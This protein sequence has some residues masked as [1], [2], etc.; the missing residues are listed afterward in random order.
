MLV[1]E[2]RSQPE[3]RD[4]QVILQIHVALLRVIV[5]AAVKGNEDVLNDHLIDLLVDPQEVLIDLVILELCVMDVKAQRLKK[6]YIGHGVYCL[7]VRS[8]GTQQALCQ[9]YS[10]CHGVDDVRPEVVFQHALVEGK[11][12][13]DHG[14]LDYLRRVLRSLDADIFAKSVSLGI[15]HVSQKVSHDLHM[16]TKELGVKVCETQHLLKS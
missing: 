2:V 16:L 1:V 13:E 15:E 7:A 9:L 6:I 4:H 8:N 10:N 12:P 3:C 11:S 14:Q 5:V